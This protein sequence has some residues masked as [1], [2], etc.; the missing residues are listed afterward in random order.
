MQFSDWL[1]QV[2]AHCSFM[3]AA[4]ECLLERVPVR[5]WS[6]YN[7]AGR[8]CC[9]T[10]VDKHVGFLKHYLSSPLLAAECERSAVFKQ[11]LAVLRVADPTTRGLP[12]RECTNYFQER[13]PVRCRLR[14]SATAMS[15]R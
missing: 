8:Y 15:Q 9:C 2:I 12:I 5:C 6:V 3:N 10:A 1:I 14:S 4:T 11:C 7:S 13:V